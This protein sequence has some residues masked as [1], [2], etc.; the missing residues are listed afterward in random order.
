MAFERDNSGAYVMGQLVIHKKDGTSQT[1]HAGK[2]DLFPPKERNS[3]II[4]RT[5]EFS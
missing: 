1:G 2:K 3:M 5:S 4:Q